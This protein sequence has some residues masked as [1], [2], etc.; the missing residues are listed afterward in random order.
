MYEISTET[1][2][3][4]AEAD[5]LKA[6]GFNITSAEV[7][8]VPSTYVNID[9]EEDQRFMGLLLDKL[10]EDDDVLDVYHNWE[11]CDR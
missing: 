2:D 1:D 11:N 6:L 3:V 9:G 8:K 7:T 5:A 10:D 4:Y